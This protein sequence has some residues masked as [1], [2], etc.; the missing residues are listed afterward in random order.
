MKHGEGAGK[1][2]QQQYDVYAQPLD[3]ANQMP[4]NPNQLPSPGQR[5][6]LSTERVVSHIPK[7]GSA[8]GDTWTYPSPQMFY[9]ALARKGKGVADVDEAEL[10]TVVAVHN[11]MNERAWNLVVNWEKRLHADDFAAADGVRLSR[12]MGRP[13]DLSPMAWFKST[14]MGYPLPFDRHDW[15]VD[16]NGKEVRYIIDFY[17]D[18]EAAEGD[19]KPQLHDVKSIKS[20]SMD[21][22]PAVDSIGS[23][24]DRVQFLV[25]EPLGLL[26][27]AVPVGAGKP[28]ASAPEASAAVATATAATAAPAQDLKGSTSFEKM[29]VAALK[30]Y[31]NGIGSKCTNCFDKVKTCASES[32]C[33]KASVA[34]TYCMA[35]LVCPKEAARYKRDIASDVALADMVDCMGRFEDKA[36]SVSA[37]SD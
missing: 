31:S 18:E 37:N 11:N 4:F 9:N 15:V 35:A 24:A 3:P 1:Q 28:A 6:V 12:F 2:Q 25:L 34:L 5:T 16:R 7:G 13:D 30:N 20:I 36:R 21:A 19:E 23:L 17:Y 33:Q 22:R 27:E 14:F 26:P 8:A 32:E 29:D 10:D